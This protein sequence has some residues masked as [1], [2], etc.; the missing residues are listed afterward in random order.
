MRPRT[1]QWRTLPATLRGRTNRYRNNLIEQDHRRVSPLLGFT[2]FAHAASTIAGLALVHQ[3][4]KKPFT[5]S[6]LCFATPRM[7]RVWE[8]VL[9]A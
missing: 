1:L 2:R 7:P 5:V 8:A 3:M 4:Q 9:A 6:A